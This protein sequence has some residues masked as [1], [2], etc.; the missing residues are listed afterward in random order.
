MNARFKI[1]GNF[2]NSKR[3]FYNENINNIE[4]E[5][6]KRNYFNNLHNNYSAYHHFDFKPQGIR[7][8]FVLLGPT[9]IY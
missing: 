2:A 9:L 5:I 3:K 1:N 4:V 6:I 8:F 7:Q